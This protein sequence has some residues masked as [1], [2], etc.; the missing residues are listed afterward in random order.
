MKVKYDHEV[1]ILRIH[2]SSAAVDESDE[3]KHGIILDRRHR[4]GRRHSVREG[5]KVRQQVIAAL[6]RLDPS[7]KQ[8]DSCSV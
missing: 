3:E 2:F 8:A 7:W 4:K 1:D 5:K 6:R